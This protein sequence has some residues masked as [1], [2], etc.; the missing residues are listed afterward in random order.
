MFG[1]NKKGYTATGKIL[2]RMPVV[3]M[4]VA[5]TQD[6]FK[7]IGGQREDKMKKVKITL[8]G[9][10]LTLLFVDI[11]D[12]CASPD[13]GECVIIIQGH[14]KT[15]EKF[16]TNTVDA[17]IAGFKSSPGG[18]TV[19]PLRPKGHTGTQGGK[20]YSNKQDLLNK[21]K[22]AACNE[23]CKNV[24]LIFIGHGYKFTIYDA[25]GN[26]VK[27]K[28]GLKI[29]SGNTENDGLFGD[30]VAKIIDECKKKVKLYAD[31]C[32]A[33]AFLKEI[34]EALA[35]KTLVQVALGSCNKDQF[36]FI[37]PKKDPDQYYL[38][39]RYFLED[40][41]FI[42]T[43]PNVM[44]DIEKEA[45]AKNLPIMVVVMHEAF[46]SAKEKTR[47]QSGGT[48][49]PV[50]T[51]TPKIDESK[52][53]I[54]NK[55]VIKIEAVEEIVE[56]YR[57]YSYSFHFYKVINKSNGKCVVVG[58][59]DNKIGLPIAP[60]ES[61]SCNIDCSFTEFKFKDGGKVHVV[62]IKKEGKELSLI[63]I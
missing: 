40:Y 45:K 19:T 53:K 33:G 36:A 9:L 18:T 23:K 16:A 17:L 44:K 39:S 55:P 62:K 4:L 20:T 22:T 54:P 15:G 2:K 3:I 59:V 47:Q 63:H 38:F 11:G 48:R 6:F 29:G 41:Y 60:I 37:W 24:V 12:V 42:I 8:I 32:F 28:H 57:Y 7:F 50:E 25:D 21:L 51:V 10:V 1:K 26:P 13:E 52:I 14:E 30:E 49:V 31:C 46:K 35:S 34:K 56:K 5:I 61:V 58:Y 43:N 27:E